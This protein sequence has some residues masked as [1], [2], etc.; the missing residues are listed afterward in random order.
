M[1]PRA[2]LRRRS[3]RWWPVALMLDQLVAAHEQPCGIVIP[4]ALA[5]LHLVGPRSTRRGLYKSLPRSRFRVCF[6]LWPMSASGSIANIAPVP[7]RNCLRSVTPKTNMPIA[8]ESAANN[9]KIGSRVS[10][11]ASVPGKATHYVGKAYIIAYSLLT[12]SIYTVESSLF[13]K[14]GMFDAS[15]AAADRST[16]LSRCAGSAMTSNR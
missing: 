14:L 7:T 8:A 10:V 15:G 11:D 1:I 12:R 13:T 16:E 4:S 6:R 5:G 9:Y 2:L 3:E